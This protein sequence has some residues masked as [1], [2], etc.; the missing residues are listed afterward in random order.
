MDE[1]VKKSKKLRPRGTRLSELKFDKRS[2]ISSIPYPDS[3]G[4]T[5]HVFE[6]E[7]NSVVIYYTKQDDPAHYVVFDTLDANQ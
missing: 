4:R 2:L 6:R 7:D 3:S 1:L 5:W